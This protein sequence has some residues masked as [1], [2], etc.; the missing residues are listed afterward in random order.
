MAP[1]FLLHDDDGIFGQFAQPV[2]IEQGGHVRSYRCHFDRWLH[3]VIGTK[4]LPIPY[5][6]PKA[7]PHVERFMRTPRCQAIDHFIFLST[8][9]IRRVV[10]AF[11]RY[12]NGARPSQAIH[13]IPDPYAELKT[14][15]PRTGRLVALPVLG[16]LIHDYRLAA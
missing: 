1:R 5:G 7:S 13:G 12:Y 16:G 2:K 4:G 8:D 15:P 14:P 10:L 6:A 3:E 9:H 11:I